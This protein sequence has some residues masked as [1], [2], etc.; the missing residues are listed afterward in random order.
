M[1][2]YGVMYRCLG[3]G[4]MCEG[5]DERVW[6]REGVWMGA[7]AKFG[8]LLAGMDR[9]IEDK[10]CTRPGNRVMESTAHQRLVN[11]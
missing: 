6:G 8:G 4:F 9:D 5:A 10:R 1:F 11:S 2:V 7:V 3:G